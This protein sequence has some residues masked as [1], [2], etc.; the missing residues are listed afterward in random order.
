M[1]NNLKIV[2]L[3][4]ARSG[5]K[6]L[7]H[8]NIKIY[9][10]L[11]LLVHSINIAKKS[12]FIND[13]IVSTD[14][15][16]YKKIAE[17]YGAKC[18]FLRPAEISGDLSTDY[19]FIKHFVDWTEQFNRENMPHLII[20][21]RPTYP[22]RKLE[23]LDKTINIMIENT[24]FTSLRTVIKYNKS[25]FKMYMTN[26]ENTLIPLFKQINSINE[27][28]NKCRQDLPD[29]YLHNGCIDIIRTSSFIKENSITGSNIYAY[30][31]NCDEDDDIDSI[32]DWNKSI[33]KSSVNQ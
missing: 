18:P 3:I 11:P 23:D 16:E 2:A 24:Q 9:K 14:S 6:G 20:Q 25:P 29:T 21:L 4:P 8:K 30:I 13:I 31:M 26:N 1:N 17:T 33:N 32:E 5:S 12:K 28:Y 10:D 19:E 22:N 15:D 27:P 7:P